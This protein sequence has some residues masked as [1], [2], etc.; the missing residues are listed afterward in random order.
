MRQSTLIRETGKRLALLIGVCGAF[1]LFGQPVQQVLPNPDCQFFFSL[2]TS[3]QFLPSGNGFDNRQ[4]GCTTWNLSVNVSGF[5]GLTVTLQS[6]ANNAGSAGSW[7]TGFAVQQK[8]LSGSNAI[9]STTGGFWWV[10]GSNAFVRVILSGTTGTGVVTGSVFGWRIPGAGNGATGAITCLTGDVQ[11]GSGTGCTSA[12]VVGLEGVPFCTGY[13]PTNGQLVQYT[14]GSSP[15]PCYTAT[16]SALPCASLPCFI[17]GVQPG[18]G[19]EP[20]GGFTASTG[21][22]ALT[23]ALT[24]G[25]YTVFY[26]LWSLPTY[27]GTGANCFVTVITNNGSYAT[28]PSTPTIVLTGPADSAAVTS[29]TFTFHVA[30][31]DT[32]SYQVTITPETPTGN[33]GVDLSATRVQ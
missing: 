20:S 14:T 32:I 27:G 18:T 5:S 2:T 8:S 29:R 9:T 23:G 28:G 3:G 19:G 11:A 33:C 1:P 13:T 17:A 10:Q 6:A 24:A 22:I 16:N 31:T 4:Q 25:T 21:S 7:G 12:T 30:S 26:Y 15:N